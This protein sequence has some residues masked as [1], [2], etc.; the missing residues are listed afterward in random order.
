MEPDSP[1]KAHDRALRE[2]DL[3]SQNQ[4]MPQCHTD[5]IMDMYERTVINVHSVTRK[6]QEIYHVDICCL[7]KIFS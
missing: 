3:V 4:K 6:L 1:E 7:Q 5:I 2:F